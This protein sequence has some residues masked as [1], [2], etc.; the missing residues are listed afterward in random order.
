MMQISWLK[1]YILI[2]IRFS[3]DRVTIRVFTRRCY[4]N[5]IDRSGQNIGDMGKE[6][7]GREQIT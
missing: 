5:R 2:Y 6:N 7:S 1:L 3:V 4:S